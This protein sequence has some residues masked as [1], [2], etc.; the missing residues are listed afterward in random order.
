MTFDERADQLAAMDKAEKAA[1]KREKQSNYKRWAQYNL[2]QT[3]RMI[4]LQLNQPRAAAILSFLVDQM[5]VYN[6]VI[7]SNEA[8]QDLL[9]ISESTVKRAI[10]V[11]KDGQFLTVLKSGKSNVY[12]INDTIYWKSW[13]K[14]IRY[15]K[16]NAAV[17]VTDSEQE[18]SFKFSEPMPETEESR[19]FAE[20]YK[21]ITSTRI[22][23]V[24]IKPPVSN[25]TKVESEIR[26]N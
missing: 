26:N 17:V 22:K 1:E 5:D 3:K 2:E 14:N 8:L 25:T 4:E 15:S 21:R 10:K 20:R 12:A 11:L 9:G 16:F 18:R 13:G 23:H 7:C 19:E 24:D 6:A